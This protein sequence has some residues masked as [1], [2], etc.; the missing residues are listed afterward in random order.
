MLPANT[1]ADNVDPETVTLEEVTPIAKLVPPS[2]TVTDPLTGVMS[3]ENQRLTVVMLPRF[4][5]EPEAGDVISTDGAVVSAVPARVV[6]VL[7]VAATALPAKSVRI[8]A[9]TEI[10]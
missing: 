8:P 5:V 1:V 10:V 2:L 3:S 9:G 6:K 7:L 4:P